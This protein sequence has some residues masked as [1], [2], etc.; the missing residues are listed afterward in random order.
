MAVRI[1]LS[2]GTSLEVEIKDFKEFVDAFDDAL[3]SG[4][5]LYIN[6]I[7]EPVAINPNKILYFRSADKSAS[8][9]EI[10]RLNGG[11]RAPTTAH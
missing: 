1:Q 8:K 5:A 4:R 11:R 6:G 10:K 2:D 9:A 7:G 3:A